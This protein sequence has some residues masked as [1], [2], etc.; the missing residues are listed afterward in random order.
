MFCFCQLYGSRSGI[1][2]L[3][4]YKPF[5]TASE[6]DGNATQGY[7]SESRTDIIHFCCFFGK[8]LDWIESFQIHYLERISGFIV[9]PEI[10]SNI[11][12]LNFSITSQHLH[13]RKGTSVGWWT[14]GWSD[15]VLS[16]CADVNNQHINNLTFG[17]REERYYLMH[18]H[19]ERPV[20]KTI[21][22]SDI[23]NHTST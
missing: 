7:R 2:V 18:H 3:S 19:L 14:T 13:V 12:S 20:T 11:G 23:A 9:D 1:R 16:F 10:E 21:P 22:W 8:K 17:K 15:G 6:I 4:C 5:E